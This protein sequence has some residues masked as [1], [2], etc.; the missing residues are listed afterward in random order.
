[1]SNLSDSNLQIVR[2][3]NLLP[4]VEVDL[5]GL[6][7]IGYFNLVVKALSAFAAKH[8]NLRA[9]IYVYE[10]PSVNFHEQTWSAFFGVAGTIRLLKVLIDTF[11]TA[12]VI[13][14]RT[15][16][17]IDPSVTVPAFH[18]QDSQVWIPLDDEILFATPRDELVL[19]N[20]KTATPEN[21]QAAP[22]VDGEVDPA[23]LNP[24]QG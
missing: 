15:S 11:R 8:P 23:T 9:T 17:Y 5:D 1:M 19:S 10:G 3:K 24:P 21:P 7:S 2:S 18:I 22:D 20:Y 16:D 4:T 12:S 13:N 14:V 6:P